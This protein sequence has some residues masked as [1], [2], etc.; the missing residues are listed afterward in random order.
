MTMARIIQKAL[1]SAGIK[2]EADKT[3]PTHP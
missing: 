1:V 3:L 2:T